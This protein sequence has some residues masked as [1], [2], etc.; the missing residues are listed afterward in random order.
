[1]IDQRRSGAHTLVTAAQDDTASADL[2][3]AL[4]FDDRRLA[5]PANSQVADPE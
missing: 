1:M 3:S 4:F 2:Q 5:G